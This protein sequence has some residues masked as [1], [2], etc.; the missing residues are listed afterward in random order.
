MLAA[1]RQVSI[2]AAGGHVHSRRTCLAP[3]VSLAKGLVGRFS[4]S[5]SFEAVYCEYFER[6]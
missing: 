5:I 6:N 1:N 3:I 4:G 2:G